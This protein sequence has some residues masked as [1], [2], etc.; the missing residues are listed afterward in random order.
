MLICRRALH[1]M[2]QSYGTAEGLPVPLIFNHLYRI[3]EMH[4]IR[5]TETLLITVGM[6][7][8]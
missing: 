4:T 6:I 2:T 5:E 3:T 8:R 7:A 1:Q